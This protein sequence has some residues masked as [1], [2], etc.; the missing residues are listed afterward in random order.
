MGQQ[1]DFQLAQSK[2]DCKGKRA[3]EASGYQ[4]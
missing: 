4:R 3:K 2:K 1:Q